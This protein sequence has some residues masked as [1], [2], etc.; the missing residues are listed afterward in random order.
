VSFSGAKFDD[1]ALARLA[2]KHGDRAEAL[3]LIDTSVT[4]KGLL[5][6]KT[7]RNLRSLSLASYAPA[8]VKAKQSSPITDAGMAHLEVRNLVNLNLHGL[9]ITDAGLKSLPVMPYLRMLQLSETQ[10]QGPGLSRLASL[11][12]LANLDLSSSA[13]TDEGLSHITGA[14]QLVVLTLDGLP[15]TSAGLK[16]VLALPQLRYLAI[17]GHM[18]EDA[19]VAQ[20]KSKAPVLRIER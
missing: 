6:L 16:H 3:H 15:L 9:P 8:W 19:D 18:V 20:L 13:V 17:R 12:N 14:S 5:H 10:V 2:T 11:G 7:F 4:D 1:A